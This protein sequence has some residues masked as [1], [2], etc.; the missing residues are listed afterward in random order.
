MTAAC[1]KLSYAGKE[2]GPIKI[3]SQINWLEINVSIVFHRFFSLRLFAVILIWC[4]V[5]ASW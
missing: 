5:P 2:S 3:S 4:V 1:D